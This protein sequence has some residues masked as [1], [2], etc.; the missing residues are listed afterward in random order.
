MVCVFFLFSPC[1][2]TELDGCWLCDA[3]RL[4]HGVWDRLLRVYAVIGEVVKIY[5]RLKTAAVVLLEMKTLEQSLKVVVCKK[6]V[7]GG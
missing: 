3:W 1:G 2:R 7:L 5:V 6:L 4:Q